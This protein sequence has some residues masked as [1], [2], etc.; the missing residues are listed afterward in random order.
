MPNAFL[1]TEVLFVQKVSPMNFT[2]M[3]AHAFNESNGPEPAY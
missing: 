1:L 2:S 3:T